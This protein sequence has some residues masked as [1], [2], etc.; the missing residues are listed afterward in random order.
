MIFHK[1]FVV[2][3][4]IASICF[5]GIMYHYII[6]H[7]QLIVLRLLGILEGTVLPEYL[8][9]ILKWRFGKLCNNCQI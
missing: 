4:I 1:I 8:V 9:V 3:I 5:A 6:L 7:Y 2:V